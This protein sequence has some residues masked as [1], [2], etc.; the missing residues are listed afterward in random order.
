MWKEVHEND[1]SQESPAFDENKCFFHGGVEVAALIFFVLF[2]FKW[3]DYPKAL[4]YPDS[5]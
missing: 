4:D 3:C 2:I 5:F 1:E